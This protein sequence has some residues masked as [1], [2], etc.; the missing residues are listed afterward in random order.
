VKFLL[1]VTGFTA[2]AV[3]STQAN[4]MARFGADFMTLF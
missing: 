2:Q 4:Q 3:S 1:P